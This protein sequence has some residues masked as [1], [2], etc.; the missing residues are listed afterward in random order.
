MV[1]LANRAKVVTLTTGT[2]TLTLGAAVGGYQ[3]FTASGIVNSN[4][5]RYV[6]EDGDAWEIGSGT[7]SA[8]TLTR[9]LDQSSTGSLLNLSGSAV[10]YVTATAADIVQ[11][12]DIG[13]TVQGY[14]A[15]LQNT[16]ASFTSALNTKLAG[17]E[18]GAT[19]DQTAA[20]IL[21]AIK[22]VDGT[23]SGLDADLLDGNQASAFYLAT[24]PS[25][26]IAANQTITL[27]G[28]LTG[29]GTTAI[30]AQIAAGAV[31]ANE[32]NVIGNGTTTQYLRSDGDGTFTW[33]T[34]PDTN[35]TYTVGNG[36]LTEINFT[37][38]L[39]TKL[40]GI[41]A[42][43]T[44]DQ[45]AAEILTAIKT[46]DGAGSGLDAD[47]LDGL[48]SA[49]FLRT[50]ANTATTGYLQ[51]EGFVNS[52]TGSLSIFNPQGASYATNT[53]TVT[54][55]IKI[56]LPQS[57]TN[58]MMRMTIRI[59]EYATNESFDVVCGGY[60]YSGSSYWIN[61]FAYIVGSPN[62]NR[63]FNV[64]F[65]HD[66]T[67]CCIY[68][69]E[70]TS[71]WSYPQVAVTHFVAG[72]SN[73]TAEQWNDN[74][75]VG[76]ATTLGTITATIT[77]SEIGRYLDG[78]V[79][80]HA[81][82]DGTG[83]GLDADL[84]DGNHASAFSL[85]SHNHTLDG[86]S[87][88][89]ITSNTAGEILKWSGT[90]WINNTLAEAGIQPSSTAITTSNIGSQSV[91]Y[92]TTSGSTTGNAATATTLTGLTST[93][94]ELNYS[95]GVTSN[96]QTQLNAKAALASPAL[97]GTPTAPTASVGTNTTQIATTAFVL[98]NA[99]GSIGTVN[100][101]E[102][103]ASG[104]WTKPSGAIFSEII[105][106]GGGQGGR[107]GN[108]GSM[109]VTATSGS[110]GNAGG[111]AI[112][113]AMA[114]GITSTVTVTVGGGG[115]SNGGT[116]GTS[117]FGA[118]ASATGGGATGGTGSGTGAWAITGDRGLGGNSATL[119]SNMAETVGGSSY[120]GPGGIASGAGTRGGGGG[121]G[122]SAASSGSG[123]AGYVRV[124][125]YCS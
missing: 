82:N 45:T 90:A 93:V 125:T 124:V 87:N 84:L 79:V 16:T 39:N 2:G 118:Y 101:Q 7:Y 51:A 123:G 56:T 12:S 115:G 102:F 21:T 113:N 67:F 33:A 72:Y 25:G 97:T 71:T 109:C 18:T 96:I 48:S 59:Y 121:G 37:S 63:N 5:V 26:Y 114:S 58:T 4:V 119:G 3:T 42:G 20:E 110:G 100:I 38:A 27:S 30:N 83:S 69:G 9:V 10:V 86:L 64:R 50:D 73:Y 91:N 47:L 55:A 19:A 88:T 77:N 28:D 89:T 23:G 8:G 70:T 107:N 105:V 35:T 98:A 31:G 117:S 120:A 99:G 92:A 94:A 85:T 116:G 111:A 1:T 14:S 34:P 6:I 22:T 32:L 81:G 46:V 54:G 57:W 61:P 103:N 41:E 112:L 15:V 52:G 29:F 95:D 108:A 24:N 66:G 44:A 74:W 106:V 40:S 43:A 62:V 75:A 53:A 80:W 122:Y 76:F 60:N 104:T 68:I 11:P 49:S 78:N 17:I 13:V 65:G 36:G